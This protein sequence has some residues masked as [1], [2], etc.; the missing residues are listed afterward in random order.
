M[1]M[2]GCWPTKYT[3][4]YNYYFFLRVP[5]ARLMAYELLNMLLFTPFLRA[6]LT[7]ITVLKSYKFN[8]DM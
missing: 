2:N 7:V 6:P 4:H 8:S 5:G 3:I 1:M